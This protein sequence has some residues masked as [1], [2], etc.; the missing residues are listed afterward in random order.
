MTQLTFVHSSALINRSFARKAV[1]K[2]AVIE[3][4]IALSLEP[5]ALLLVRFEV[6]QERDELLDMGGNSVVVARVDG[7][8]TASKI[9]LGEASSEFLAIKR[10]RAVSEGR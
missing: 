4:T 7:S 10:C 1:C 2:S 9:D 6:V 5:D 8:L 3:L